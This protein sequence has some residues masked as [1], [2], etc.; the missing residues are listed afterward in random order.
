MTDRL[1]PF[2]DRDGETG[3][4]TRFSGRS[5][6]STASSIRLAT[7]I[8]C[9]LVVNTPED[10]TRN[11]NSRRLSMKVQRT[12]MAWEPPQIQRRA[13]GFRFSTLR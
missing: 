9:L 10:V 1:W 13:P 11:W 4:A 12:W 7:L 5:E 3:P 6:N 2:P 8:V